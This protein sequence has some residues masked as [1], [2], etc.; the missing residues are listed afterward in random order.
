MVLK[1]LFGA[2]CPAAAC[3]IVHVQ[4][5]IVA[6]WVRQLDAHGNPEMI[7]QINGSRIWV[8]QE[9][10]VMTRRRWFEAPID[11]PWIA[12]VA[13]ALPTRQ[14]FS[15]W[16]RRFRHLFSSGPWQERKLNL[17]PSLDEGLPWPPESDARG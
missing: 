13:C 12:R 3:D 6:P 15:D 9:D 10:I 1:S 11:Q 16:W 5:V 7:V 8:R 2:L 17:K 14:E 4:G